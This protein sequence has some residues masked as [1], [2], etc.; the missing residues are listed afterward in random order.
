VG[1]RGYKLEA[2]IGK[3]IVG[4]VVKE[5][6]DE[7]RPQHQMFFEFSDGTFMELYSDSRISPANLDSGGR[8]RVLEYLPHQRVVFQTPEGG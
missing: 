7:R 3:Q 5:S 2:V 6:P 1:V 8:K 4:V